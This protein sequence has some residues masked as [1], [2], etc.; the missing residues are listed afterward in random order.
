MLRIN[1]SHFGR[2]YWKHL[3]FGKVED[4]NDVLEGEVTLWW[5]AI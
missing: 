3:V 1:F 4:I 5:D 2:N